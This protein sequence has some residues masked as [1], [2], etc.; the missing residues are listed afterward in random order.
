[1]SFQ[2]VT[3]PGLFPLG[4]LSLFSFVI[5]AYKPVSFYAGNPHRKIFELWQRSGELHLNYFCLTDLPVTGA[6]DK[7][8]KAAKAV[9]KSTW[10]KTHKR[11][12]S[13]T[14]HR[15]KTLKHQR[16]PKYPRSRCL[17]LLSS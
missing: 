8:E 15:P 12:T 3:E 6:K 1:M 5:C 9:K 11:R 10:K 13:V 14:F 7:A 2:L 17:L 16:E 4:L